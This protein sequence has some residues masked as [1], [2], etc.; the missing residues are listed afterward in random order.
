MRAM[1]RFPLWPAA[2]FLIGASAFGAPPQPVK[3][4]RDIRPIM[5]DTCFR[6]HGPDQKAR[7]AGLRLDIRDEALKRTKSGITPVVP[8][9]PEQSAIVQRVFET[10]P[11]KIMPPKYAHKE[12]TEAQKDTI[13]RWVAE[14]AKYEGHWAYEPV[15]RPPLPE[16]A[17]ATIRNPIDMFIQDRL[18]REGLKPSEEADRRTLLRRLTLDLTGLP[19]TNAE[20]DE[21]VKDKSPD[22]YDRLVSRLLASPRYAEMQAMRWLDAVRYA[23]SSGFHGDNLWPAWPYRDYVLK[24]FRENMPFDRFTREQI[25]GDLLPD[26]TTGQKV[27]AAY[28]R[29]NR[30]SAEGGLQPKEYLAKYGA[31]RVRTTTTVWM[32]ATMGCAECHDHKFDPFTAKDFYS[33]KAFFA[34]IRETGLVPDRGVKAWGPKLTLADAGEEARLRQFDVEIRSA[35]EILS[36]KTMAM[37]EQRWAWEAKILETYKKGDLEWKYQ[38][39][40]SAEASSAKLTIYNDQP[41]ESNFYLNGSLASDKGPGEGLVVASGPNPDNETYIVTFKPGAGEWKAL[42]LEVVQDESL[43]GN[44]LSRGADRFVLSEIQAEV[45]SNGSGSGNQPR[46]LD[47][48]LATSNAFGEHQENPAMAAIDGDAK[49]GWGVGFGEARNQFLALRLTEALTTQDDSVVT[50][51]LKHDSDWR[52]ATIGRFRVALSAGEHSWPDF[53]DSARKARLKPKHPGINT[54]NIQVDRGLPADVLESLQTE[55]ADRTEEQQQKVIAFFQW[56]S[57]ALQADTVQIA[58]LEAERARFEAAIPRVL[59]TERMRPRIT[60]VLARGNFLDEKGE[61]VEPAIPAVFGK[62][63]PSGRSATRLDLANWIVSKD[64]PL[65]ARVFVNRTWR[66]FFGT[67]IS[68]ILEDL[69]SQGEWPS[70]PELIDWLASEFMQSWD[71]KNL[72]KTIV[73]SHTYRQ[74]SV[75]TPQLDQKDPDNRLLARQSRF[76][77][78]AEVVH[79]IALATSGLL[80]ERFGGP[81]VRPYQP[82]G[83]FAAMNFPKREYA[84]SRGDDLHRRALYTQWQRTFLHP[85]LITFDAPTREECSVN[86]VNSNTPLQALMLLNDPIFVEAAQAFARN[87]MAAGAKTED[88]IEWA[89]R[90][91][92]NRDPAKDEKKILA[93]LYKKNLARN[94]LL[95]NKE[96]GSELTAMTMV[97]RA[98]LNLHEVITRN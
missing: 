95:H 1:A 18:A 64:N 84:E 76:R 42:G 31:D 45:A 93:D 53:G 50:L 61:I 55:E 71:V 9:N 89:F 17:N 75:S 52:R 92:L 65:T 46:K 59:L 25:A 98:I 12:L 16:I 78:D 27:A 62:I 28:N 80:V 69:G 34:D 40:I 72:V 32:G 11:A 26:A 37:E 35:K 57:P 97:T 22:A 47:F 88:R 85:S 70:H 91:A 54:L 87:A 8:G 13:R 56:A 4:N 49:S 73:T 82:E 43:P 63:T 81:S 5:S 29:L 21:F 51:R 14:G 58:Q 86:R 3:F 67:G 48:V 77:V 74:S 6:C 36:Q 79:D 41:V 39:P 15:R 7:M 96:Q 83:Y 2:L 66:Q 24:A 23:D 19:P 94:T 90:H 60:R 68:K 44:R 20:V 33:M 38:R 30:V 10:N